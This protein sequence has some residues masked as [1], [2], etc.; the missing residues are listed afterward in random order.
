MNPDDTLLPPTSGPC[1]RERCACEA[2][3]QAEEE[4]SSLDITGAP[5][6]W[7]DDNGAPYIGDSLPP[8]L[9]CPWCG[10][11]VPSLPIP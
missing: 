10:K 3:S 8:I 2:F 1:G 6:V 7:R 9:F 5:A 11:P 4:F